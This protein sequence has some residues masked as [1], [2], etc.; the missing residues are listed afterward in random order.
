[1]QQETWSI[2]QFIEDG[3]D[4]TADVRGFLFVFQSDNPVTATRGSE[5][6]TGTYSLFVDDGRTELAMN[7][8]L[9]SPLYELTDDWYFVLENQTQLQFADDDDVLVFERQ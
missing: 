5:V 1:M 2:I 8:D 4:E 3:E 6:L 9:T 7:F